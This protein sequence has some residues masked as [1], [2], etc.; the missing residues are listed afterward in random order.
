MPD[1]GFFDAF[2]AEL[3]ESLSEQNVTFHHGGAM[4]RTPFLG[5]ASVERREIDEAAGT[6]TFVVRVPDVEEP[7]TFVIRPDD[8]LQADAADAGFR[9]PGRSEAQM[10]A[11]FVAIM[12][13]EIVD[14]HA[15]GNES[16]YEI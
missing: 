9:R 3:T 10:T 4:T 1:P 12:I 15:P 6:V 7:L 13:L 8:T 16:R 11:G 5:L 2:C 14:T